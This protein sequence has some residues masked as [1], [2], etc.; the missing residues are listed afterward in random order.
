MVHLPDTCL[1]PELLSR[2]RMRRQKSGAR[3]ARVVT[4]EVRRAHR[5]WGG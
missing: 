5:Y 1:L 3:P 4:L 2:A